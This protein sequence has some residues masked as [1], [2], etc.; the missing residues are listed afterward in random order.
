VKVKVF[1]L[2]CVIV[3]SIDCGNLMSWLTACVT[4]VWAERGQTVKAEKNS[5]PEEKP[6]NR[7]D[8]HTSG[9]RFVSPVFG[10]G[11]DFIV[12]R[13]IQPEVK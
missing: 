1:G 6:V 3:G 10:L 7:A 11:T 2:K 4:R 8:S 13:T 9:A 12:I 5:K